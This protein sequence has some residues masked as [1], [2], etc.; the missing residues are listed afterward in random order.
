LLDVSL[1][2]VGLL[3]L[4]PLLLVL[5]V[6]VKLDTRGPALYRAVRVGR[7]GRPFTLYKFRSMVVGADALGPRVTGREDR[8]ITAIGRFLRRTK[9][10]ELPQLLNVLAGDMSFVGPRPEDPAYVAQYSDDE[11]EVL[12]VR[13]GITSPATLVH[14]HEEELLTG[15]DWEETYRR[16]LLPAKLQIEREYLQH[17]TLVGDLS[18]LFQTASV[19]VGGYVRRGRPADR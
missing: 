1:S 5:A 6:L 14:H 9:L 11:R 15:S 10:D 3:L 19:L 4:S 18:V 7:N 13:P 2:L 16:V 17:R 12:R 8:R